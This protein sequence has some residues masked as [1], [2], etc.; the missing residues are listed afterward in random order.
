MSR[1]PLHVLTGFLGSGKTTLLNRLLRDPV[2]ADSAVVINEIGAVA[3]DHYLVE[4]IDHSDNLDIV[5][6]QGGCTCCALRGDLVVALRELYQRRAEGSIPPFARVV[7]E[8]TGLADPAP[9]LFTLAG[10]RM[11]RHK[12]EAGVVIATVDAVHGPSQIAQHPECRSQIGVADR[13]VLTKT[14]LADA[15]A[16]MR[17]T[18]ALARINPAAEIVDRETAGVLGELLCGARADAIATAAGYSAYNAGRRRHPMHHHRPLADHTPGVDSISIVLHQ[19]LEWSAFAV[20]LTLLL[21]AHGDKMLRFKA[22]LDI[23]GWA[24]PVALD[25]VHHL[26]HPPIHLA[27]W[28]AGP[29][30]SR[31]VFI[32][33]GLRMASIEPS[34]RE[35]I[36]GVRVER[37]ETVLGA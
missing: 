25:G 6:L 3:I 17:L 32:A 24:S 31:L 37:R 20:W 10:D 23:D 9:I 11:L 36:A 28:P 2:L 27:A 15:A 29:R 33:Q 7:L 34:L 5:V 12:F 16:T 35:F 26:I 4:R 22:L 18:A 1:I 19:P 13:L 30:T 14:D 21:H 8:T